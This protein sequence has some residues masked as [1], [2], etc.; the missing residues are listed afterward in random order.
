VYDIINKEIVDMFQIDC[1]PIDAGFNWI[2]NLDKTNFVVWLSENSVVLLSFAASEI[3]SVSPY[4]NSAAI[5]CCT[6][7]S[8]Q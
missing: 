2:S 4:V 6:L 7:L 5:K 8:R 1:L 3:L